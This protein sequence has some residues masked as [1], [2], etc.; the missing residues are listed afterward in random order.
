MTTFTSLWTRTGMGMATLL[1]GVATTLPA[2]AQD[3]A[4]ESA[5]RSGVIEE[6]IVTARKREESVQSV[7]I[8]MTALTQEIRDSSVRDLTDLNA[9]L[10]NV[11]IDNNMARSRGSAINIRGLSYTE[12]DKSFDPPVA[13]VLDGVFIGTSSGQVIENFDLER[14]EVLR[15]PQ[16]TLFGK[17]T[18]GGVISA[19]RSRP[20]GE[21]GGNLQLTGGKWDQ[22][23][24][25]TVAN[26]PQVG[27]M[28]STKLF[29]TQINSDGHMRNVFLGK[30]GPKRDY[31]NY[32]AT[33]L[34]E[35]GE[36]FEA[37]LTVETYSDDSD[38]GASRNANDPGFIL[39]DVYNSCREPGTPRSEYSTDRQNSGSFDTDAVSLTMKYEIN[40]SLQL[41]SV[42]GWRDEVEDTISEF[43]GSS[44]PY[45]WI[46]NKNTHEQK[47]TELRLEGTYDKFN[48]VF[49][50]FLWENSYQQNWVTHGFFWESVIPGLANNA[51]SGVPF[52]AFSI[53]IPGNAGLTDLC[54]LEL[55]GSLRCDQSVG[56]ASAGL[57]PNFI[58]LLFQEQ[59]VNSQAVFFQ[60]DYDVTDKWTVTAGIRWTREEK[61]FK[62]AQSYLAPVSKAGLPP[63]VWAINLAGNLD[64]F[65]D[66][67][68]WTE[69]S[70]KVGANYN[71]SEDVMF[72]GS[73]SEGF[74]SGGYFGRNQNAA[75]FANTY[76]PEFA[77]TWE[78][79]MKSQFFDNTVQLNVSAFYNDFRGKQESTV[80]I[81]SSTNTVVTVID[82]VGTVDYFGAEFELRWVVNENLNLFASLGLL[83]AEYDDFCIDLD[84][85]QADVN[86]TSDCGIVEA[87][88]F[89]LGGDPLFLAPQDQ[90]SLDPKFAPKMTFGA[91]GTYTIPIGPGALDLHA[92]YNHIAK[93][94]TALDNADGTQL[95]SADFLNASASYMWDRYR[96]T[97]YGRNLT[98]ERREVNLPVPPFFR[99][100]QI[101][102][103]TSWGIEVRVDFGG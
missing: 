26:L 11:I 100:S 92:R 27:D 76:E 66:S 14:I 52:A 57:G 83:H 103:G 72:Y 46:D 30:D 88:G 37:L 55:V 58:Q 65:D 95:D 19:V 59:D 9:Y 42:T 13:V 78:I 75:D 77:K 101:E 64:I 23:E 4:S 25:R 33:L 34:F 51:D 90:S 81:D 84:G 6:V 40:E 10:P 89:T 38:V 3:S 79:G 53:P 47:S 43:D 99:S 28:L 85:A 63:E 61:E 36:R 48:F 54:L 87:A 8:A 35:P 67:T 49:G 21:L 56:F 69:W 16:G 96:V 7:P 39:C 29:F 71:F 44:L 86:P 62:G 17:N 74:H 15:G 31:Q 1:V 60:G 5:R 50:G 22:R 45:I 82:N 68:T 32:G 70:P 24:L 2:T 41:V 98:D 97:V 102:P 12:T 93:Q 80:K 91:G 18:V 20:T 73:Y 94:E